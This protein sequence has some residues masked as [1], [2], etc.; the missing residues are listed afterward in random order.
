MR[1][2]RHHYHGECFGTKDEHLLWINLADD[3]L[4]ES[5]RSLGIGYRTG[6][7]GVP[8]SKVLNHV[9]TQPCGQAGEMDKLLAVLDSCHSNGSEGAT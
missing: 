2:L 7:R 6:F 8:V 3:L 9:N 5:R 1:R 4:D